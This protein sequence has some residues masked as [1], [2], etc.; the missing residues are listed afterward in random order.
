MLLLEHEFHRKLKN[1]RVV[2][3]DNLT[4][5]RGTQ[6]LRQRIEACAGGL[7]GWGECPYEVG[8]VEYIEGR[9]PSIAPVAHPV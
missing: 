8:V 3:A 6:V 9:A 7:S 4:E 1:S 5:V 2:C